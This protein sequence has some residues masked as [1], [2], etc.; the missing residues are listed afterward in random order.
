MLQNAAFHQGLLRLFAETKLI[1]REK[2][3]YFSESITCDPINEYTK[4][5][6][7][8]LPYILTLVKKVKHRVYKIHVSLSEA[9]LCRDSANYFI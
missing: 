7:N 5:K 6:F 3:Q 9:I 8:W 4:T 2:V 1:F